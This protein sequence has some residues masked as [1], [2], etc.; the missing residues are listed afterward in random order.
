MQAVKR[1]FRSFSKGEL[2]LWGASV[3]LIAVSYCAFDREN[4]LTL[5]ASLVGAT[6]LIFCAK[7]N[8]AGQ[9]RGA[10]AHAAVQ[11]ALRRHLVDVFLLWR[12]DHLSRHDG[13]H[14]ARRAHRV[15][16]PSL[17][18]QPRRGQG[19][20]P[21]RRGSGLCLP[22][23]RRRDR[24]LLLH[25]KSPAHRQPHP[26]HRFGGDELSRGVPDLPPQ[27]LS[28]PSKIFPIF[29]SSSVL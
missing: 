15:A 12:D 7:G 1:F 20:P 24:R 10:G 4:W 23:H 27:P 28:P 29:P 13:A 2:L 21:A 5:I 18:G 19:Q 25:L 11:R 14:G 6:S 22:S 8:P 16:P 26:E 3:L 9:A 17:Q